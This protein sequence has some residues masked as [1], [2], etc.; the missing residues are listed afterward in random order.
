MTLE[1]ITGPM[2]SGKTLELIRRLR[3]AA[4]EGDRVRAGKPAIDGDQG[5]LTS[6]AGARWP[7][8]TLDGV[9][10]IERLAV[11]ASVVGVDEVQFLEAPAIHCLEQL[12]GEGTRVIA[13]GLDLD[14]R[15]VPF[16]PVELLAEHADSTTT[17]AAVCARCGAAATHSQ[18][19]VEGDP[20]PATAPT[21]LVGGHELYEPRCVECHEVR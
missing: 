7:A 18:R 5:W 11:E 10:S 16:P 4:A 1:L 3:L 21:I 17:L 6:E 13:A 9:E 8:S 19:L 20:A 15:G 14:F 2:F 12:A